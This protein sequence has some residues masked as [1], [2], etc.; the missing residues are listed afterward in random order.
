MSETKTAEEILQSKISTT[1]WNFLHHV[2]HSGEV[3]KQILVSHEE[4]ANQQNKELQRQVES[5]QSSLLDVTRKAV[6]LKE[7]AD[8]MA[9]DITK[10]LLPENIECD[11]AHCM[12]CYK[13]VLRNTVNKYKHLT[14]KP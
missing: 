12:G 8:E 7:A 6:E 13:D 3:Y 4:Y 11:G 1:T 14:N 2:L 10:S 9:K 5:L